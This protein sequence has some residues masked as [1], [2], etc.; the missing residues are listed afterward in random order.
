M[1][2]AIIDL[3]HHNKISSFAKSSPLVSA[4]SSTKRH[5]KTR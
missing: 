4:P 5:K 1:I 3:S 2:N